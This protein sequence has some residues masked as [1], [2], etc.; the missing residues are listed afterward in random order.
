MTLRWEKQLSR[1][2]AQVK[3]RGWPVPYIRLTRSGHGSDTQTWFRNTFFTGALWTPGYFGDH[4]VEQATVPFNVQ[5]P[6]QPSK[7][8]QLMVTHDGGREQTGKSTPNTWV[9]WDDVTRN[10]LRA[11]NYAGRKIILERS[12][13]GVFSLTII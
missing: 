2:D 3:T 13:N 4:A 5:M 12:N 6:G 9:H 8:R 7:T 10:E 11:N 1:S